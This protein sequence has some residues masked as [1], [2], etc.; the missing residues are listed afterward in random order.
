M[1]DTAIS[2]SPAKEKRFAPGNDLEGNP[3]PHWD[4]SVL[5]GCG[6]LRS[7]GADLLRY[8][9]LYI[10][11]AG[12]PL[13]P[14][15]TSALIPRAATDIP[16]GWEIGLGWHLDPTGSIGWHDGGTYG[17]YAYIGF[18]RKRDFG[19]VWL[20]NGPLWQLGGLR[21]RLEKILLGE[22]ITPLKLK[23]PVDVAPRV[24]EKYTGRYRIG[25]DAVLEVT[26]VEGYLVLA[27]AGKPGGSVL[28]PSSKTDFFFLDSED[29][30]VSFATDTG[31]RAKKLILIEGGETTVAEKI[32]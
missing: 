10:D 11:P 14:A 16:G 21:P 19:L 12:S 8:L 23:K 31:G 5:A 3:A 30:T 24:L 32:P 6:A 18:N 13:Q 29:L 27:A 2:V 7:T 28:Y 1:E 17:A 20:S 4:F 26:L 22:A 9:S 15:V 25:P